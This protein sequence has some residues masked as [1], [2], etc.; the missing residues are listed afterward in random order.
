MA[1]YSSWLSTT[2]C[3]YRSSAAGCGPGNIYLRSYQQNVLGGSLSGAP[4]T[5]AIIAVNVLVFLLMT[6]TGGSQDTVNLYQWGAKYGPAIAD[7]EWWRLILPMFMH[8]GFFHLLTNSIGLLIFGSMAE[9][10]FG[11]P[12]YLA[13]YLVTGILGNVASFI[14]SP[15]LGAGASGAVFGVI[16][17]FAVYLVLNRRVM[18]EAARQALTGVAFI[19]VLNIGIGFATAGIDNAAHVGGLL[20]GILMALIVS[21]RQRKVIMQG[22]GEFGPPRMGVSV[23]RQKSVL[24]GFAIAIGIAISLVGTTVRA[25]NYEE[26]DRF[27]FCDV[28]FGDFSEL[29]QSQVRCLLSVGVRP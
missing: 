29:T 28:H 22:W 23:Q 12:T 3:P 19:V 5:V 15:A 27:D 7:G 6:A 26:R 16:G 9:K 25:Q 4:V 8:I 2:Y 11:S 20:G 13:I 18:G 14:V 1:V 21:P 24:L 10:L 17:A